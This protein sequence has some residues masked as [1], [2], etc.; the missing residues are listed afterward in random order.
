MSEQLR[1]EKRKIEELHEVASE[2]EACH[3]KEEVYRLGVDAA[4]GILEFDICGIDVAENGLLVPQATST[5]MPNDGYDALGADEGLAGRTYQNGKSFLI[6]DVR[7][8]EEAEPIQNQYRSIL[9]VPLGD[10][11][12]FQAGSRETNAFDED[13]LELA[14]L[15]T[16][17]VTE[18]ISRIDSQS[19]LRESEEKYRTLVEGSHDAIFIHSEETFQFVN[20]RVGELTGY[21]REELLG[22]SIWEVVHE[23]DR[24]RVKAL[25]EERDTDDESNHYQLR[26]RT[27][28]DDVRYVELSVQGISYNGEVGHLGS[29]RDVTQRRRRKQKLERQNDRLKEFA[30]VVSHDLRNPLNVAQ[31]HLELAAETG[32]DHHFEKTESALHRMESL[33][34]D[35][36]TLA[37]EGQAVSDTAPVDL[38]AVVRRAWSTVSTGGATLDVTDEL[39]DVEADDGRLQELFENLFRNAVQHGG[40]VIVRVGALDRGESD[41]EGAGDADAKTGAFTASDGFYVEDDGPG[42]PADRREKVFEHGHT[43]AD[44]GSGLGLSIVSSIADAHGWTVSVGESD[45]GGARFEISTA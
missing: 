20:D 6:S 12:V 14:E 31:G 21:S 3:D 45:E 29:A 38:E 27:K 2:M 25:V 16:S 37:R 5:E 17:H 35:L 26:I 24:E 22:T 10:Y 7:T 4:E 1:E 8:M 33:I 19:A 11:G 13:D 30:S 41:F 43:T 44:E 32:E 15:L 18:V 9:S 23:E 34:E 42:I 39:G 40:D 28:S 36:L